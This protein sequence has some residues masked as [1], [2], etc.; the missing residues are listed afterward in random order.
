MRI[1]AGRYGGRRLGRPRGQDIRPTSERVREALFSILGPL[2]GMRV[3]DLFAG[4][5][6]LGIEALS[7]GA[8]HATFVEL[9]R[10]A[11]QLLAS[12]VRA[13]VDPQVHDVELIKGNA[14]S[15][16]QHDSLGT[17]DLIFVDPPYAELGRF[18]DATR[19][20][21]D[22]LVTPAGRVVVECE[23]RDRELIQ[24]AADSWSL[25]IGTVR[26]YGDTT[27]AVLNRLDSH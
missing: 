19:D 5:G 8:D 10:T 1:V 22:R 25:E 12:N 23:S 27:I 26:R 3:A 6:A 9:D 21:L 11:H 4:T 15:L 7:R 2:D 18:I 14:V 20:R 16:A 17:F 24:H 13:I